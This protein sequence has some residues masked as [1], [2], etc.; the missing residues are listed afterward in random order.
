MASKQDLNRLRG[1]LGETIV[2]YELM[3]RDW[4]VLK[5]LGGHG[6]D[7][8]ATKPRVSRRV[9]VKTTDPDLRTGKTKRQL[10]VVLTESEKDNADFLIFYIHRK[11][12]VFFVIP[13]KDFPSS[14]SVTVSIGKDGEI[15][16]GSAYEPFRNR[17]D[18]LD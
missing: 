15:S 9:E 17:W 12:A 18:L 1:D 8:L 13:Q 7:L 4:A 5:N 6:Y 16:S 3:K 10:T 14:G 2:A 11:E